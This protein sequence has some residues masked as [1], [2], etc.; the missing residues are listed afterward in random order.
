MY[1]NNISNFMEVVIWEIE[2]ESLK[3][4]LELYLY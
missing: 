3:F 1:Y 2:I 4:Y